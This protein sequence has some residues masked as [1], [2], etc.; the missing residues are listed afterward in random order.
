MAPRKICGDLTR[1]FNKS[2]W[3]FYQ[4]LAF[5]FQVHRVLLKY[6]LRSLGNFAQTSQEKLLL[7]G[8]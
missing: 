4:L 2:V 1:K 8:L 5:L 6:I 3:C 7:L